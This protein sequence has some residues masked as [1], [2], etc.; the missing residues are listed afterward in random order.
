MQTK[1][2]ETKTKI[3]EN[4][5]VQSINCGKQLGNHHT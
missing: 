5:N 2:K 3:Y 1:N 4:K